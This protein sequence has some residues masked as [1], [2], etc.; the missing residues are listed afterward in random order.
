MEVLLQMHAVSVAVQSDWLP[1]TCVKQ[2]SCRAMIS[3]Y[4]YIYS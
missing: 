1:T 2:T 4:D 3:Y